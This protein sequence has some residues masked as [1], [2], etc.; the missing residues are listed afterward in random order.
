[1]K[2]SITKQKN[3][4]KKLKYS[5]L[6]RTGSRQIYWSIQPVQNTK[7]YFYVSLTIPF[8]YHVSADLEYRF[9]GDELTQYR[10]LYIIPYVMYQVI[11]K[12]I[13]YV[14]F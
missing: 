4:Q 3:E 14:F 8:F 10:G 5:K 9:P 11:G 13:I 12:K 1:M 6:P 7:G 2:I